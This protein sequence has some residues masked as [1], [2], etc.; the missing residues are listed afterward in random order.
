M[1]EE[2]EQEYLEGGGDRPTDED[3][4]SGEEDVT[5]SVSAMLGKVNLNTIK[6]N[7][8]AYGRDIQVLVDGGSTNYFLDEDTTYE[9]GCTYLGYL[10]A[11]RIADDIYRV[12]E[13][14]DSERKLQL[15]RAIE[16]SS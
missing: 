1:T 10:T 7:G 13:K 6:I 14:T 8:K 2:Q 12:H 11:S 4:E 16:C 15:G 9:L 3:E 5:V